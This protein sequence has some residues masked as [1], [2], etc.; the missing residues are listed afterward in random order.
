MSQKNRRRALR[1]KTDPLASLIRAVSVLHDTSLVTDSGF[2]GTAS[3]EHVI[4]IISTYTIVCIITII[5]IISYYTHARVSWRIDGC[6][7]SALTRL[8]H[9]LRSKSFPRWRSGL[10]SITRNRR[11]RPVCRRFPFDVFGGA[12]T[13]LCIYNTFYF[14]HTHTHTHTPIHAALSWWR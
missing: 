4:I 7:T 13:L 6:T 9:R 8:F 2:D 12:I 14:T 11:R 10:L 1:F 5:I 3:G